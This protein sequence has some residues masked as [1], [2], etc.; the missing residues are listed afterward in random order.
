M[1]ILLTG[2]AGFI[3]SNLYALLD[4]EGHDLIGVDNLN[5]YYDVSLKHSRIENKNISNL[6]VLD[7][8]DRNEVA[9]IFK[10]FL[11]EIVINLAAQAGVRNSIQEP[12]KYIDSNISGFLNILELSKEFNVDHLIY[13]SSSSVYGGCNK[14]P[15]SEDMETNMPLNIY[16]ASKKSNEL[17]AYAYSSLYSLK[18]TG[19]RFF[20]V[21]G[22]WDR[23]DMALTN[24]HLRSSQEANS[25]YSKGKHGRDFTY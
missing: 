6:E 21:Y 7:I 1:R 15:F 16:A 10:K 18:T 20:T 22:P 5:H 3:G 13:A 12:Q 14:L 24:L 19:L 2:C 8:S 23:P 4:S 25:V 9:K 11:P 17:M